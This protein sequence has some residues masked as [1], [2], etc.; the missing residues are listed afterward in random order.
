MLLLQNYIDDIE[1]WPSFTDAMDVCTLQRVLASLLQF[2][3][4]MQAAKILYFLIWCG[5][6]S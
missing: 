4:Y 1:A 5:V 3:S 2:D 6:N